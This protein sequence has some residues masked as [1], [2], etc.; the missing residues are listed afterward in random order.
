MDEFPQ[1]ML[2]RIHAIEES[3]VMPEQVVLTLYDRSEAFMVPPSTGIYAW[4][5]INAVSP[6]AAD[7]PSLFQQQV[8]VISTRND[9]P[10]ISLKS[11]KLL[12]GRWSGTIARMHE[13]D[14]FSE[15]A[16]FDAVL[17][18]QL[19]EHLN[20]LL[21]RLSRP[22]YIGKAN[23]LRRRIKRHVDLLDKLSPDNTEFNWVDLSVEDR[24]FAE[25]VV[26]R[27]ARE[28]AHFTFFEFPGVTPGG[29]ELFEAN[30][31]VELIC[32]SIFNPILGKR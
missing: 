13:E 22:V 3:I 6:R 30:E 28:Q 19:I 9:L 15:F 1:A 17:R 27:N 21:M 23:D 8:E 29:S 20:T 16:E 12:G 11:E 14:H 24:E 25:R 18:R 4:F 7:E 32:N 2:A 26:K 31:F 5:F 10:V